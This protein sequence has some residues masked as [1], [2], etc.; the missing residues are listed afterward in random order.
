[1]EFKKGQ[2][3]TYN[4]GT[5]QGTGTITMIR[6]GLKGVFYEVTD[7]TAKKVYMLRGKKLTAV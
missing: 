7:K 3:V 1:M 4:T 2:K 5:N 6:P